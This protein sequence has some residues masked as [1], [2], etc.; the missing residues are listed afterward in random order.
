MR[1]IGHGHFTYSSLLI[2]N[3]LLFSW[4]SRTMCGTAACKGPFIDFR[5]I[6][7]WKW[8]IGQMRI[9]R[10]N[11][12][13]VEKSAPLPLC[14]S[15]IECRQNIQ[16]G[17]CGQRN[18]HFGFVFWTAER[19]WIFQGPYFIHWN[20]TTSWWTYMF[21]CSTHRIKFRYRTRLSLSGW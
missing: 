15:Q 9:D 11:Q 5:M 21:C 18:E 8:S 14:Q 12:A 7:E 1:F 19:S 2:A 6:D 4:C 3:Y 17:Y 16:A 13:V 20:V 10:G